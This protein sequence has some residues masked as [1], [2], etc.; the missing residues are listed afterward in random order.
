MKFG[1]LAF[2][3]LLTSCATTL[4]GTVV[5]TQ[6]GPATFKSGKVNIMSLD[7]KIP[8]QVVDISPGGEFKSIA[9]LEDGVYL[10]EVLVPGFKTTSEKIHIKESKAITLRLDPVETSTQVFGVNSDIELGRGEGGAKITP[11]EL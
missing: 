9:S 5:S 6:T 11:P 4:S 1:W 2:V 7:N 8:P 10:I 3:A